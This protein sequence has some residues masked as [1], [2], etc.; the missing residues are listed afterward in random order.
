M[1]TWG[2]TLRLK[3]RKPKTLPA[4]HDVGDIQRLLAEVA[5]G[6]PRQSQ[7]LRVR[8][9]DFSLGVVVVRSGKGDGTAPSP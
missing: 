5:Q 9:L 1:T 7:E 4:Y 6:L 3:L 2:E 8:D